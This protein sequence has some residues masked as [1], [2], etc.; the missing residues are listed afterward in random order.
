[1]VFNGNYKQTEVAERYNMTENISLSG[2]LYEDVVVSTGPLFDIGFSIRTTDSKLQDALYLADGPWGVDYTE[3]QATID[4]FN[5]ANQSIEYS[6]KLYE[7]ERQP[8][9]SGMV[10][11]NVNL[12]RHILPGDQ[13]LDVTSFN[14]VEFSISNS[15]PIEIILMPEKITD[16]NN[17]LRYTIP[18][19]AEETY[20]TISFD[21]FK[22]A[23]GAKST[24]SDIKTIVFSVIGNYDNYVPFSIDL[25]GLAFGI[26]QA[27]L[28]VNESLEETT[29]LINYPNPFKNTT[30]FELPSQISYIDI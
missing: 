25:N 17:R 28:G 15:Q 8:S 4:F 7:V 21:D 26:S 19:N 6:E 30:T 18:A 13:T 14:C 1:M 9:V 2:A 20:Y 29:K 5:V 22:D 3:G 23:K 12:F 11:D 16:W 10:K 27:T 24:L